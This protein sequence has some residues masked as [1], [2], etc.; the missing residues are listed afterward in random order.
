MRHRTDLATQLEIRHDDGDL[1]TRDDDDDEDD[2]QKSKQVVELVLPDW[3]STQTNN[4][5][6]THAQHHQYCQVYEND[7][8]S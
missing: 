3:L 2:K 6:C 7:W 1:R 5:L 4:Q 8:L